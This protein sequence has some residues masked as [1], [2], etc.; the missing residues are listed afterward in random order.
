MNPHGTTHQSKATNND[1][2]LAGFGMLF[3][4]PI[5]SLFL[6]RTTKVQKLARNGNR[7]GLGP[8]V[9]AFF[10]TLWLGFVTI[11]LANLPWVAFAGGLMLALAMGRS[12]AAK[13]QEPL[14]L[15]AVARG[16]R[17]TPKLAIA[18]GAL[19][20]L[21]AGAIVR[22]QIVGH[23]DSMGPILLGTAVS[24]VLM[25]RIGDTAV[26]TRRVTSAQRDAVAG[27]VAVGLSTTEDAVKELLID[28]GSTDGGLQTLHIRGHR[29][30]QTRPA[31][32]ID[33]RFESLGMSWR[34]A[35]SSLTEIVLQEMS[36]EEVAARAASADAEALLGEATD[37]RAEDDF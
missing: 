2:W 12:L 7:L 31:S 6:T 27:I 28:S 37:L 4:T 19:V 1:I 26:R 20:L 22:D 17:E 24:T 30:E 8:W 16:M 35:S 21:A 15:G 36:D 14:S 25:L 33:A 34:A 3:L 23:A 13:E 5:A 11:F 18:A 32:A 29:A 10:G 9:V